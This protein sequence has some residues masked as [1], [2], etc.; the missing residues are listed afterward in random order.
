MGHRSFKIDS[1]RS[2]LVTL[3]LDKYTILNKTHYLTT[4]R[5]VR[6]GNVFILQAPIIQKAPQGQ[7]STSIMKPG[8]SF[9]Q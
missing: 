8:P 7:A 1:F 9:Q 2:K 3:G 6:V 5:R 4:D